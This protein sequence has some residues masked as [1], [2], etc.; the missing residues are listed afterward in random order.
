MFPHIQK[1]T[2]YTHGWEL[3]S[4]FLFL[5]AWHSL[6]P[7]I[8]IVNDTTIQGKYKKIASELKK[9]YR[10]YCSLQ[11]LYEFENFEIWIL[12]C[13]LENI[14]TV[15]YYQDTIPLMLTLWQEI[16][17]DTLISELIDKNYSFHE[18][19]IAHSYQKSWDSIIIQVWDNEIRISFWWDE[20]DGLYRNGEACSEYH[21]YSLQISPENSTQQSFTF[22]GILWE[23]KCFCMLDTLEFHHDYEDICHN[24]HSSSINILPQ[25]IH[26]T[27]IK[28]PID[29][30]QIENLEDFKDILSNRK[31]YIPHIFT[32]FQS[33]IENFLQENKLWHIPVRTAQ[34]HLFKSFQVKT[35]K[36]DI[37][38]ICDDIIGKIFVKR[39]SKKSLSAD[40]D[41]LLKIA[42][43]DH[44]VHIDHGVG[45]FQWIIKKDLTWYSKEYLEIHYKDDGKLFVPI[46][47]IKRISKYVGSENPPLTPL[48]GKVWE[49]K[50]TKIRE[51]IREIAEN[52][53]QNFAER[54]LRSGKSCILDSKSIDVF[55]SSF[56]YSYTP[57]QSE[58]IQDIFGDMSSDKNMDRLIV[59]DVWFWKTEVACNAA[60][61]SYI[62]K[63]QILFLSPL[64]V[65]A[66]EHYSSTLKR[67]EASGMKIAVLTRLQSI[68]EANKAM[69]DFANGE[70]DMLVGTHKLLSEKLTH[71][72]LWLLIVDEEHKFWVVDK[73]R[74]KNLKQD[75][76]ILSLS[77]TPIP[78]S[79]NLAL[80]GV[81][82]I[83]LLKTPPTGRKSIET[84]V[85]EFNEQVILNAGKREFERNG[86]IFF[87]HNRLANIEVIKRQLE[88]LF[89]RKRVII[90]HGQL[91]WDELEDR[92][93]A[94]KEK[95]YDILLSTTVI[96][97]GIDFSNVNTIFINECQSFWISQ[98]HQLRGRVWRS[99]KQWYCYLLYRKNH[100]WDEAAKRIQTIVD[101][102]YLWAWFE[103]AM[104]DLEIRWW[105][106]ILGIKQSGQSKEIGVSL[107]LKMLE[108]KINEL[109]EVQNTKTKIQKK[110]HKTQ[111]DLALTLS[112]SEDYFM[113]DVDRIH[114]YRE[115]EL[116]QDI[117]EL[118]SIWNQFFPDNSTIPHESS[119]FFQVL[120]CQILAA[121][122]QLKHIKRQGNYYSLDFH[123]DA[124]IE[125]LKKVLAQDKEVKFQ[126]L[127]S[128]KL[129]ANTKEFAND[130]IFLK[131]LLRLFQ[132]TI[133]NPKIRLKK[134]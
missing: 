53:L 89:P 16:S 123:T 113:N 94:F 133:W 120:Q 9:E 40:M 88:S 4:R 22:K 24:L 60:Y 55:Q 97:N 63:K 134:K 93:L 33:T 105:W 50:M 1:N 106:D 57:D 27:H 13:T 30:F 82:D 66:H 8:H 42:P 125:D 46:A 19:G 67:F 83:S 81:R 35:D 78:R 56:P 12:S 64:V 32:K 28:L 31:N 77:A 23:K 41:L 29:G 100:M 51:D 47:E 3:L 73:E 58:A 6:N 109:K 107:F 68:K 15:I 101:Y 44:V 111:I 49:K 104:K 92:I 17:Q 43:G 75:I 14:D 69:K 129:R 26:D 121:E 98:I 36:Q 116:V 25:N 74:I 5:D 131:Y 52:I 20:I 90:G 128:M 126:V 132:W 99:E 108:E 124:T 95:K 7:L 10:R 39:R 2:S 72:N 37:V 38:Y 118:Q 87:V 85:L 86:Q 54:K 112:I 122:Y 76:D 110:L 130:E 48:S 45:V 114:F 115:L 34:T 21:I 59:G 80:S 79:L 127:W 61:L 62:N 103:L 117:S 84:S 11:D 91:Q 70:I 18:H 119:L 71:K 96:E 65:L 102:S